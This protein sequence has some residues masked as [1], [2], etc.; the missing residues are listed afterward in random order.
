MGTTIA[1][2]VFHRERNYASDAATS[3][4]CHNLTL[5]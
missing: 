5:P 3:Q 4:K 2:P 1:G